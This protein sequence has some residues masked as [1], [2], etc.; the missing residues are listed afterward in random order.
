MDFTKHP[1][2]DTDD[3]KMSALIC[4]SVEFESNEYKIGDT[5]VLIN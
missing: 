5:K 4:E 1:G 3:R 2:G